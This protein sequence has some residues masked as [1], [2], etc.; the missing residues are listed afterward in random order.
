[1][2]WALSFVSE[3]C[4]GHP[5]PHAER[6]DTRGAGLGESLSTVQLVSAF[7]YYPVFPFHAYDLDDYTYFFN[8]IFS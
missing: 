7:I 5:L 3:V 8:S 4:V 2:I 6:V 1:M